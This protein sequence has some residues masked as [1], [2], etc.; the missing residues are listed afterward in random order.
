MKKLLIV[1][2][3]PKR[4]GSTGIT[5][6][7]VD[8]LKELDSEEYEVSLFDTDFF[9]RNHN[10]Q[11]YP[12]AQYFSLQ[13][14]CIEPLVRKI[15]FVRSLYAEWLIRREFRK[16]LSN[17]TYT[18]IAL[19]HTPGSSYFIVKWAHKYRIKVIMYPWGGDIMRCSR[20]EKKR[21][22]KAF[23]IVDFVGGA[24]KSN[25]M[26][27]AERDYN[28]DVNKF[29]FQRH[30]ISGV[31]VLQNLIGK[32]SRKEMH[33]ALNIP[34]SSCNIVCGYNGYET[35]RHDIIIDSIASVKNYL[36][37]DYQLIFPLSYG[38]SAEY[39][40]HIKDKCEGLGLNAIYI[41]NFITNEQMAYLHLITD[42]FI[43]IQVADCGNAFM[44]ETIFAQK[45][46]IT[47]KW[48]HYEQFE[49]FGVPYHL[50]DAPEEL[51]VMLKKLFV[52]NEPLSEI[53]EKLLDIF[54][55]PA[56]YKKGS[57]W[58]ELLDSIK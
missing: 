38:A 48:L 29:K 17:N 5:G 50:I 8:S 45:Q 56:N 21:I 35:H 52:G 55:I 31:H 26:L 23:N 18:L 11:E 36:P 1:S 22:Q 57:Y 40:Q 54:R 13:K 33:E 28:V 3:C 44:I 43:N 39:F 51:P 37:K 9:E 15:P 32:K 19:Y 58:A 53:P 27:S 6:K 20:N 46:I 41:T 2:F 7:L 16:I 10:P 34:I 30:Y 4:G 12:V 42:Y 14:Y 49:Q 24:E 47:G 25:C